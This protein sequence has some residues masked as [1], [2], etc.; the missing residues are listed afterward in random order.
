MSVCSSI[1]PVVSI[2]STCATKL[3]MKYLSVI[4]VENHTC[5]VINYV[6]IKES[7]I[8]FSKFNKKSK[9]ENSNRPSCTQRVG[10]K[11]LNMG[12]IN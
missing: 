12:S 10:N 6:Q 5:G 1:L 7:F 8:C 3:S 9:R 4:C 2:N 11:R